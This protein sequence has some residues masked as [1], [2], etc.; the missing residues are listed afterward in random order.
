MRELGVDF[1][2]VAAAVVAVVA[3]VVARVPG[4]ERCGPLYQGRCSFQLGHPR[5]RRFQ[6]RMR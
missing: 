3:V 1:V 2:V 4:F 6:N 5:F